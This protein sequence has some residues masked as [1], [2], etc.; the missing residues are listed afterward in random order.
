MCEV[1]RVRMVVLV[2]VSSTPYG[3]ALRALCRDDHEIRLGNCE[4]DDF[5]GRAFQV[6]DDERR[7]GCCLFDALKDVFFIGVRDD[8]HARW[9]RPADGP[10]LD[11]PVGVGVDDADVVELGELGRK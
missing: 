4:D 9:R 2:R 1:L 3:I 5:G 7:F 6:D 10:G 8:R 11:R